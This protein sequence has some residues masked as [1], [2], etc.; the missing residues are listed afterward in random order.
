MLFNQ[1]V[2]S[3]IRATS[4]HNK[5]GTFSAKWYSHFGLD[6]FLLQ[7]FYYILR[8]AAPKSGH[9]FCLDKCLSCYIIE[10]LVNS[11]VFNNFSWNIGWPRL[12]LQFFI[13]VWI[14]VLDACC[15]SDWFRL[16]ILIPNNVHYLRDF[17]LT[18]RFKR[19]F[20]CWLFFGGFSNR[21]H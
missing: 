8:G 17:F 9:M 10:M 14:D 6:N 1:R 4:K 19:V 21:L 3:K 13:W 20:Q 7:H 12:L 5:K 11:G 18:Y 2:I 15:I 16:K